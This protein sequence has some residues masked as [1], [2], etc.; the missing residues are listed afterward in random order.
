MDHSCVVSRL[1]GS[2]RVPTVPQEAAGR[3]HRLSGDVW[4]MQTGEYAA[5]KCVT[6]QPAT[7]QL[8]ASNAEKQRIRSCAAGRNIRG[9]CPAPAEV[10]RRHFKETDSVTGKT[11]TELNVKHPALRL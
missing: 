5:G 11:K 10:E 4:E 3:L 9:V 1:A 2:R 8:A 6:V 7:A